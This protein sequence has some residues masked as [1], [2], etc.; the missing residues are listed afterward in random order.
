MDWIKVIERLNW[1]NDKYDIAAAKKELEELPDEYIKLLIQP[2]SKFHWDNAA[3]VITN[4]GVDR[5][6][7]IMDELLLW[8]QDM[9]WPG[10]IKIFN[11]L[12]ESNNV[13]IDDYIAQAVETAKSENDE[14]WLEN[15]NMLIEARAE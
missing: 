7:S 10:A 11:M 6:I 1:N 9:N 13:L 14:D 15:I 4:I 8:I 3:E 5:V 12:K 2:I